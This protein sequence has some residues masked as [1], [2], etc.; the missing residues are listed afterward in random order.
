MWT[1][2]LLIGRYDAH[3][4]RNT[5]ERHLVRGHILLHQLPGSNKEH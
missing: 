2:V 4:G 3:Y 1:Q 5:D